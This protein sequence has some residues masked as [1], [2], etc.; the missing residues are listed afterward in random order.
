MLAKEYK[1]LTI[2]DAIKSASVGAAIKVFDSLI[3]MKITQKD[4]I[5]AGVNGAASTLWK[6]IMKDDFKRRAFFRDKSKEMQ[7]KMLNFMKHLCDELDEY[8]LK[9]KQEHEVHLQRIARL[10]R[11]NY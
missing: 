9:K 10:R 5:S 1:E 3:K 4:L 8:G 11:M 7:T 6:D 2:F